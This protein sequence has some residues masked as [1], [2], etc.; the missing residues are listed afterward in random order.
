M[1]PVLDEA[2]S[3]Y[4]KDLKEAQEAEKAAST[5]NQTIQWQSQQQRSVDRSSPSREWNLQDAL[6]GVAGVG[7]NEGVR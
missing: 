4:T 5:S 7:Y 1:K 2:Y 6:K 3:T